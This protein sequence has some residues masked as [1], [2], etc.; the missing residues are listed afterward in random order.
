VTRF[1][2]VDTKLTAFPAKE[3]YLDNGLDCRLKLIGVVP[4]CRFTVGLNSR[5]MF[6]V[7][8]GKCCQLITN[9]FEALSK[10]GEGGRER[11][12]LLAI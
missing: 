1:K 2:R 11:M 3:N 6:A 7:T 8:L 10:P 12:W 4:L 5:A 9:Y